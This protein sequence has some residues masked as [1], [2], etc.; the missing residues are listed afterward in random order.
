MRTS[1]VSRAVVVL[2]CGIAGGAFSAF[3]CCCVPFSALAGAISVHWARRSDGVNPTTGESAGLGF[4]TG[5]V[6]GL[7]ASSLGTLIFLVSTDVEAI[8]QS[9]ELVAEITQGPAPELSMGAMAMA[10][11]F[12]TFMATTMLSTIGGLVAGVAV[13]QQPAP[14][15]AQKESTGSSL[16]PQAPPPPLTGGMND[17]SRYPAWQDEPTMDGPIRSGFEPSG[18]FVDDTG[19]LPDSGTLSTDDDEGRSVSE[20]GLGDEP[21]QTAGDPED[22]IPPA[23]MADDEPDTEPD[24]P[25]VS[26]GDDE[27]G[28]E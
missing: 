15:N 25:A 8:Q 7:V 18:G 16:A 23:P 12:V 5:A 24:L 9:Q 4:M 14:Q 1:G 26:R 17:R 2:V 3:N 22:A 20:P 6:C 11:G 13:Q 27:P 21:T 28:A 10:Y 19:V